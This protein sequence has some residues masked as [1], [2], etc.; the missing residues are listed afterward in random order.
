MDFISTY[1]GFLKPFIFVDLLMIEDKEQG[2]HTAWKVS[3]Y[4]LTQWQRMKS[5][6]VSFVEW[7]KTTSLKKSNW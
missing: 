2:A 3:K 4:S 7:F 6:I 5:M 1:S